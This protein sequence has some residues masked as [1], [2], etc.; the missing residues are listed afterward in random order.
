MKHRSLMNLSL[1]V[2]LPLSTTNELLYFNVRNAPLVLFRLDEL[3][4][5]WL[6]CEEISR[7]GRREGYGRIELM[8]ID[9]SFSR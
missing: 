5:A 4:T 7:Y 1:V 6:K 8:N 3:Q 2:L 9:S